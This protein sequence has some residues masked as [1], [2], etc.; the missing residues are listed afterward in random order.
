MLEGGRE[1]EGLERRAGLAPALRDAVE[2]AA[3][4]VEA[5]DHRAHLAGARVERD[6]GGLDLRQLGQR[7]GAVGDL[8]RA[9]HRAAADAA[10]R[11]GLRRQARVDRAQAGAADGDRLPRLQRGD[12]APRR[13]LEHDDSAQLA[14]VG[15]LGQRLRD[16]QVERGGVGGQLDM[17]LGAAE[18]LAPLERH[19]ALAHGAHGSGL[20][21]RVERELDAQAARVGLVAEL[22][23]DHLARG[24]GGMLGVHAGLGRA[25]QLQHLGACGGM[26]LGADEADVEHAVE[27]MALARRGTLQVVERVE[28]RGRLRQ[29]GEHR[30]LGQREGG[31]R[32][33]EVGARRG[34]EAVRAVAEEDLVHVHLEDL[35]LREVGLD[36]E[37]EQD[38][39]DLARDRLL[40]RQVEV[41]RDLHRDRRAALAAGV[42]Q[43]GQRGARQADRVDAL[44]LVEAR[45]LDGQHGLAQHRREVVQ[46]G[47]LAPLLAELGQQ[48]AVGRIYAQRL[49]GAVVG[50][51]VDGWQVRVGEH[52]PDG[53][54]R[55]R[56]QRAGHREAG[57]PG[58]GLEQPVHRAARW[59]WK[60]GVN[61]GRPCGRPGLCS[62]SACRGHAREAAGLSRIAPRR[63]PGLRHWCGA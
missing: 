5:A 40:G 36:L 27:H 39:V 17:A 14:V 45:V 4:E 48:H 13:G 55:Q 34:G 28:R 23:V 6:E 38:L 63:A 12:D 60:R 7:P 44:V 49:L 16:A 10:V 43:V 31:H 20:L 58:Q 15:V 18:M 53:H 42:G 25:A 21:A 26:L 59:Q 29:A 22:G 56:R 1:D 50:Q 11:R 37:R 62:R 24:L 47:E 61:A 46:A 32:L 52:Q 57:G 9:Q 54:Q 30:G 51:A 35:V 19:Q 2:R 3:A 41:A 8:H 33:A